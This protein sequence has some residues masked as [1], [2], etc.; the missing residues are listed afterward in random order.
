MNISARLSPPDLTALANAAGTDKG[1]RCGAAHG[2]S[3]IYDMVLSPLKERRDVDLLEMGLAIGGP[4][5]SGAVDRVVERS[6][7][8]SMWLSYFADVTITGFD[9]SDFSSIRHPRFTFV[10][11]DSGRREDVRRILDL[12]R[13]FDVILDDASHASFHQQLGLATLMPALKPG[14]LYILEDLSWQPAAFEKSLPRVPK[15]ARVL[16]DFLRTGRVVPSAA[17]DAPAARMLQEEIASVLLF[18]ESTLNALADC[19]NRRKGLPPVTRGGWRGAGVGRLADP[20]F[21]LFNGRRFGQAVAGRE[22]AHWQSVKLA[23][24]QKRVR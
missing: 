22:F 4:E 2:Y 14:G 9:I 16:A 5:L 7:S 24:V 15:T 3:L 13:T 19:Y 18:G 23:I 21:W 17:I 11:G 10:R 20:K 12:G 1:T 8:L 6:P